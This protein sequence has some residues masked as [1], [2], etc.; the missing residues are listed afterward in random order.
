MAALDLLSQTVGV[1]PGQPQLANIKQD[2]RIAVG[3]GPAGTQREFAELPH[4]MIG[5]L[6]EI[7]VQ[8]DDPAPADNAIG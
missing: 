3:S 8:V 2:T 7:A 4:G 1:W 5:R 6:H